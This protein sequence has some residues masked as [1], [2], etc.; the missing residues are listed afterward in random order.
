MNRKLLI[1]AVLFSSLSFAGEAIP[2]LALVDLRSAPDSAQ[3]ASALTGMVG[4]ELQRLG[5]FEVTTAEQVRTLTAFER[6]KALLGTSESTD[7]L[8]K[9]AASLQAR[10]LVSGQ[11]TRLKGDKGAVTLQLDLLDADAGKNISAE[12]V[13]AATDGELAQK[14]GPLVLKLC[15]KALSGMTGTFYADVREAGATVKIDDVVRGTSPLPGR[16]ELPAGPHLLSVERDGFVAFQKEIRVKAGDHVE[17]QVALVPSTDFVEHYEAKASRM[18]V[19]AYICTGVL[20]AGIASAG[21]FR[22]QANNLFGTP[23][24]A[25]TFAFHQS[26][27]NQGV[28]TDDTG[29]HRVEAQKLKTQIQNQQTL[30]LVSAGVAAAAGVGAVY[31]FL[32]GDPPGKYQRYQVMMAAM[33]ISGGGVGSVQVSF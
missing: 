12:S 7:A 25:G 15:G 14:V 18:R 19:G 5:T 6:Q 33:P 16:L 8:S 26:L 23:E 22:Y 10:Y 17:E 28:E 32:A 31:L 27:L 24:K 29:D 13:T 20:V 30:S 3:L 21:Y 4:V 2:K 11:V 1:A 9:L